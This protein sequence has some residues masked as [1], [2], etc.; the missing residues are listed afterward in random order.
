MSVFIDTGVIVAL[1]NRRDVMHARA[2]EL[3]KEALSSDLGPVYTSDY[4]FDEAVTFALRKTGRPELAISLGSFILGIGVKPVMTVLKVDDGIF[5]DAW[6]LFKRYSRKGLS[7]TD[8]TSVALV[9]RRGIH[10]IMS[11]DQDFDG[12]IPRLG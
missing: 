3:F 11:F 12:I 8:C 7:F 2:V 10:H 1:H 5:S 4:I 6:E 9:K